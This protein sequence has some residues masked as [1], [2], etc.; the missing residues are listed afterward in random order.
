L[1]VRQICDVIQVFYF[2]QDVRDISE[3]TAQTREQISEP[4]WSIL[5]FLFNKAAEIP[6]A[7]QIIL[8]CSLFS[9]G[10]IPFDQL[11]EVA[12]LSVPEA[13]A[14]VDR[15]VRLG[16]VSDPKVE[17]GR[18]W[19]LMQR[20]CHEYAWHRF[21]SQPQQQQNTFKQ[22]YVAA[23][24]RVL[25]E[26]RSVRDLWGL[27]EDFV[28]AIRWLRQMEEPAQLLKGIEAL[29]SEQILA[30]QKVVPPKDRI[31]FYWTLL[32][33][34]C[35]HAKIAS[36]L[37]ALAE[38]LLRAG[39]TAVAESL[40]RQSVYWYD[41]LG[42]TM[43]AATIRRRLG[44]IYRTEGDF[45]RSLG[46]FN[47][48]LVAYQQ[49]D[50]DLTYA[51]IHRQ[52]AQTY[53]EAGEIQS[54]LESLREAEAILRELIQEG[55]SEQEVRTSYAYILSTLSEVY[56]RLDDLTN[57]EKAAMRA[58]DIHSEEVGA[59]HYYTGYDMR[60]LAKV[61]I[62][63]GRL[64]EAIRLLEKASNISRDFFGPS[65]SS[66]VIDLTIAEV[67]LMAGNPLPAEGLTRKALE[68][69]SNGMQKENKFIAY[70]HR[71]IAEAQ[72]L[73]NS[74]DEAEVS[75]SKA[76]RIIDARHLSDTPHATH[77]K[78]VEGRICL[79]RKNVHEAEL[80][81][82]EARSEFLRFG[83]I[84]QAKAVDNLI[85]KA[86]SSG[87]IEDWNRSAQ[88][89]QRYLDDF[90][91]SLHNQLGQQLTGQLTKD[92]R[93]LSAGA[94]TVLD[95]YCGSGF[96]SREL[97]RGGVDGVQITGIDG[98]AEMI[99]LSR[100]W[101]ED[102]SEDE[103]SFYVVPEEC[104]ALAEKQFNEVACHM[105]IFQNDL[106]ARHFLFQRILARLSDTCKIWF[107]VYAADFQFP[108]SFE[109]VYPTI[110]QVNP[111][112]AY[113][114]DQLERAG[115]KPAALAASVTPMFAK[116]DYDNLA[117]FF[118]FYG[119]QLIPD[120]EEQIHIF[121]VQRTWK[122]RLALT[123]LPV[124]SKKI[125][126]ETIPS[127]FW[128]QIGDMP[129]YSDD[130]YGAVFCARRVRPLACTPAIFSHTNLD[131][132]RGEPI[133]Y[134]VAVA[135]EDPLGR[136]FFVRR[137]SG[138]RDYHDSWSLCSTFADPGVTLQECLLESLQRNL[139][140]Q[141]GAVKDLTP[142]SIRFS[143]RVSEKGEPWIMAM[144]LY[145]ARL[146]GEPRLVTAKYSKMVWEDGP[147]FIKQLEPDKMGDCIKSYRD[148]V[149]WPQVS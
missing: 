132:R 135:L 126:G 92:L 7:R 31:D 140:I 54:A 62:K 83:M 109:N 1:F 127:H 144:C 33:T 74:L 73:N 3:L 19:V 81:F 86:I 142:R 67:Q 69:F 18:S 141:P 23:W 123:R 57:A 112:K 35:D 21:Q 61:R 59:N 68:I 63:Q 47:E 146:E 46:A 131:F 43:P 108:V 27:H 8:A 77:I 38:S 39:N 72:L 6:N 71:L 137:G 10:K 22:A 147:L 98:S 93:G 20:S 60:C 111:F 12:G 78:V 70:A 29:D 91:R 84:T 116:E 80:L 115:Y 149:H 82:W 114:F 2:D 56:S 105:G 121:P 28:F 148:L 136:T 14:A 76:R 58:I 40:A 118:D 97:A 102:T 106:R 104:P 36:I 13:S 113:L 110:N 53:L 89:Y 25:K 88:S 24:F 26:S 119:F 100:R 50:D 117:H 125:F 16:W 11:A 49:Q 139:G 95:V 87:G 48:A 107:S 30:L 42:D 133:R 17:A 145:G 122:D 4:T 55:N 64:D 37:D 120:R 52:K 15:I 44:T 9:P 94:R 85:A 45:A 128:R 143:P 51:D 103:H 65:P 138:A 79:A 130:T 41:Q 99:K 75:L 96:V 66:A 32:K 34:E 5:E 101:K 134:A 124:I 129:D 90:S